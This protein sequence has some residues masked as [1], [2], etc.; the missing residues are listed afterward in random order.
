MTA[1]VGVEAMNVYCGVAQIPVPAL[2]AGR[3]LDPA[4]LDNLMMRQRSVALPCEDPVTNAVNAARP[5]LDR[6][7][8]ETVSRIELLVTSTESGLDLSKSVASYV[9]EFLGLSRAC[10]V[11]EVKQACY[12][13]TG[14]L[15]LAAGHI[16]SGFSP[17]AKALVIGT[18]ISLV[19]EDAAYAEPAMGNGAVALLV[20]DRP[21]VLTLDPGAFGL[22][23]YETLDSARPGPTFDIA[24]ADRSL[25][26]YLDC[27]SHSFRDYRSRVET[28]DYA[29]TFDLLA[30]HT[31]FAGMVRAGHRKMMREFAGTLPAAATDDFERRVAPSLVYPAAVGNMC[32]GS[33]YLALASLVDHA[34]VSAGARVGLFSYGSGCSSEFFSGLVD[35]R[36]AR[37][38]GAAGIAGHLAARAELSFDEYA[39]LLPATRRSLL[40]ER[41]VVLEPER[42]AGLLA[43]YGDR[44][45]LLIR[46][47]TKEHH[48]TYEWAVAGSR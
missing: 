11:L 20:G 23:S 1:P 36:S 43:R 24:D 33:V 2:F 46:T 42:H 32:S 10:R 34:D 38:V 13:A 12:A 25:Y 5:L 4:R 7:G 44:R 28:A 41:D 8:P 21:E 31:P 39:G 48:R 30:M 9:H 3:G 45:D 40:P 47:G 29:T 19:D 26:A 22:Y 15:Q 6:L 37:A 35:A 16:A 18:D 17:G 27:L 14:A